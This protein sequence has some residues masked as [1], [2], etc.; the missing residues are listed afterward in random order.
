M[1]FLKFFR[2][3]N[4]KTFNFKIKQMAIII[5][6]ECI[7]CGACEPECPN[8]A[9]YE[10]ADDWRYK[11]GTSLSG[12]IILPDGTEVDADDAQTPISD[13]VY[14]IVPGK[15]TECKGFHDEPQCAAVCPVDCCVPDDNHVEDEETLLNRQA[16]L[17]GE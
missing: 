13:E 7:N 17:H 14:Y 5:T 2:L 4:F 12:K 8:T 10:G 16:F 1:P 15:C 9:I 6:D 3:F 11:D